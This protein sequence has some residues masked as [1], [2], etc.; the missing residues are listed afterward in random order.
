MDPAKVIINGQPIGTEIGD[1]VFALNEKGI[2]SYTDVSHQWI[3]TDPMTGPAV[4]LMPDLMA[5]MKNGDAAA[6]QVHQKLLDFFQLSFGMLRASY[7]NPNS[8]GEWGPLTDPN[9]TGGAHSDANYGLR[10]RGWLTLPAIWRTTTGRSPMPPIGTETTT[11]NIPGRFSNRAGLPK[12]CW[13]ISCIGR[14]IRTVTRT[15]GVSPASI[16]MG[17]S[18]TIALRARLTRPCG[19]WVWLAHCSL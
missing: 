10:V 14:R 19:L 18:A 4:W 13:K 6:T 15:S 7:R 9:H 16:R 1:T 12:V 11:P 5:E 2:A 8:G 17:S 3:W